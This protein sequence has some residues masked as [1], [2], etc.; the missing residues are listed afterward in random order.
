MEPKPV[1]MNI[2]D[3]PLRVY[4]DGVGKRQYS[5]VYAI[6]MNHLKLSPRFPHRKGRRLRVLRV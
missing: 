2:P 1:G 4:R 5:Y 3:D 6:E